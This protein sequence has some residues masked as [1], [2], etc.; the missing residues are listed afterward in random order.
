[1][2]AREGP[3]SCWRN[4]VSTASLQLSLIS[5]SLTF[6]RGSQPLASKFPALSDLLRASIR[7]QDEQVQGAAIESPAKVKW[8]GLKACLKG[9]V[10]GL[11]LEVD[12]LSLLKAVQVGALLVDPGPA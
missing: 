6:Y 11:D 12:P 2:A 4:L 8:I 9:P 10:G 5:E 7:D 1:L 3:R